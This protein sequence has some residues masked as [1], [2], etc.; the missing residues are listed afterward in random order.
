MNCFSYV[1]T[2]GKISRKENLQGIREDECWS[3]KGGQ[4]KSWTD[5]N[6]GSSSG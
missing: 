6:P 3:A 5:W 4:G 1:S 2:Y